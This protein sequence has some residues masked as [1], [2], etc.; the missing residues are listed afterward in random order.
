MPLLRERPP[1]SFVAM[2]PY[3]ILDGTAL[4]RVYRC[5]YHFPYRCKAPHT[6]CIYALLNTRDGG[7]FSPTC[8]FMPEKMTDP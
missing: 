7:L 3:T 6:R 8:H 1:L 4:Q 5:H 2:Y